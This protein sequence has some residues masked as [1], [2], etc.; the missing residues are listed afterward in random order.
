MADWGGSATAAPAPA[1]A[2]ASP[3]G[4]SDWGGKAPKPSPRAT[5]APAKLEER[6]PLLDRLM[7]N[8][9]FSAAAMPFVR[10][11][12]AGEEALTGGHPLKT[13]TGGADDAAPATHKKIMDWLAGGNVGILPTSLDDLKHFR[14][15]YGELT[16]IGPAGEFGEGVLTNPL[17]VLGFPIKGRSMIARG[18]EQAEKHGFSGA[19]RAG[20]TIG[21]L[22]GG[23]AITRPVAAAHD[24]LGVHSAA[25]RALANEHGPGW[26]DEY[27]RLRAL[28][29]NEAP[30]AA[31]V[32]PETLIPP[33]PKAAPAKRHYSAAEVAA[34]RLPQMPLGPATVGGGGSRV[35]A[36]AE[37]LGRKAPRLGAIPAE[38]PEPSPF[39]PASDADARILD[40]MKPKGPGKNWAPDWLNKASDVVVGGMF[41]PPFGSIAHEANITALGSIVD[42]LAT[43]AAIKRGVGDTAREYAQMVPGLKK[44]VGPPETAEAIAARHAAAKRGGAVSSHVGEQ[45]NILTDSAQRAI[46]ALKTKGP[47]GNAAAAVLKFGKDWY[48]RTND[49]LWKF[50]DEVRAQR[51]KSLVDGGM[52]PARAGLRIGGEIV[53]YGNKSPLAAGLKPVAPFVNWGLQMPA[54]VTRGAIENPGRIAALTAAFPMLT[55]GTQGEDPATGKPYKATL[56][57][58]EV[59][60]AASGG[61]EGAK[62]YAQGRV[63]GVPRYALGKTAQLFTPPVTRGSAKMRASKERQNNKYTYGIDP[64]TFMLNELPLIGKALEMSGHGMFQHGDAPPDALSQ[65]LKLLRVAP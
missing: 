39:G 12:W 35:G 32:A 58:A 8:K 51:F 16:P 9:T 22:P 43:A 52:S 63:G 20:K 5:A 55:G 29:M 34:G 60:R 59:L 54:A 30:P 48:T 53:D 33:P 11:G 47:A 24:V 17:S 28:K 46:D 38:R 4:G 13:L 7:K 18:T 61:V 64:D 40:L 26:L 56:P 45:G 44:V 42:P 23:Q 41:A 57:Q 50:D 65:M 6:P 36:A 37:R 49:S 19:V 14:Q 31:A 10:A 3:T 1:A 62:K 21:D 2:A 25:K 27:A 15:R